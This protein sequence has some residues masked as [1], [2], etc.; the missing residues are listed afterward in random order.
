MACGELCSMV[1]LVR[2]MRIAILFLLFVSL[3]VRA[4]D[5]QNQASSTPSWKDEYTIGPGDTLRIELYGK[6]ETLRSSVVVQPD[7]TLSYLQVQNLP[8]KGLTIEQVRVQIQSSLERF[9]RNVEVIVQPL[10]LR[11]KKYFVLGRVAG[12]GAY[13]MDHPITIVEAVARARGIETGVLEPTPAGLADLSRAFLVRNNKRVSIDFE[14][15]FL[16]GDLSQNIELEPDDY[17]Y[18]PSTTNPEVYVTGFVNAPARVAL[19][20]DMTVMSA[21]SACGGFNPAAYRDRVL[22]IRGSLQNPQTFPIDCNDILKGKATDMLLQSQDII[23]VSSRPWRIAEDLLDT[24]TQAFV[25][26]AVN[27]WVGHNVEL[28]SAVHPVIPQTR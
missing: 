3:G 28:G 10:V 20:P 14:K 9:F 25:Q 21:L 11:S 1:W 6:P 13:V 7:G 8:V 15:L 19:I 16:A 22:L 18:F 26:G 4:E 12:R 23:Y 5:G 27:A 2:F 24:A 17:L